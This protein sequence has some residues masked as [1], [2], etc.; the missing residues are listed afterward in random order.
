MKLYA[1]G[2]VPW[3]ESQLIYHA[4]AHL[5]REALSLVSPSSPY[6]CVGYHQ[7]VEQEVDLAFCGSSRIPVFRRDL[8]GG[9]VYLDGDQFFFQVVLRRENP[10]VTRNREA[11]YRKFLEPVVNAYRRV[12]IEVRYKPV[13][14]VLAGTRKISGTGVGEIGECVVFV[15]N[16]ILDF[17]YDMMA[18]VLRVPDEKFRDKVHKTLTDNLTTVRRELGVKESA[19]WDERSLNGLL[20]EE[21]GKLLGRME[22]AEKD[23]VLQAKIDE[24]AGWMLADEWLLR[25]GRRLPGRDV[26][27][28][29]GVQVVH[30]MHKAPGG[31]IRADYELS[32]GRFQHV[33]LSGD[34]FCYPEHA[35]SRLEETLEGQA[36]GD[37]ARFVDAFY[38]R[39]D[40]ET[41]G[42]GRDDWLRVLTA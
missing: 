17:N 41:P 36:P 22:P 13:N 3:Q 30:R 15:G 16:L 31:L 23:A 38:A 14:D 9:A 29:S 26:K 39:G 24:L 12:G 4:L 1:L 10:L 32:G 2:K 19:G 20:A 25:K 33:S 11:F 5:G 27:I 40:V 34:F 18:R 8:G 42:I 37:A 7:D 6:V 21:F 35:V 28:R